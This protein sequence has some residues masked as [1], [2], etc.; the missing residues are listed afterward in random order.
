[1]GQTE[2]FTFQSCEISISKKKQCYF[3]S[4]AVVLKMKTQSP[5]IICTVLTA[6]DS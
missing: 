5:N 2:D 1:M 6:S 3:I 4:E